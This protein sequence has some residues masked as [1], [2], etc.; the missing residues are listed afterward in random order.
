MNFTGEAIPQS[1]INSATEIIEQSGF[2][3]NHGKVF[4]RQNHEPQVV[5]GLTVNGKKPNVP[6][7]IRRD[8]RKEIHIFE[9]FETKTLHGEDLKKR[10]QQIQGKKSYVS[11]IDAI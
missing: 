2:P 7:K 3:L 5:V 11:Y 4:M 10:K 9:K 1:F 6:R 8:L